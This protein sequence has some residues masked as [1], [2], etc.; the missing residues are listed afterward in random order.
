MGSWPD[1]SRP[2]CLPA[3]QAL[4]IHLQ[5]FVIIARLDVAYPGAITACMSAFSSLTWAG[6][7]LG[8]SPAC[9]ARDLDSGS[10]AAAQLL[11]GLLMPCVVVL[12]SLA[13]WALRWAGQ[14]DERFA[15]RVGWGGLCCAVR[16]LTTLQIQ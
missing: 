11:G 15:V 1:D 12:L 6:D 9:L 5:Y 3:P 14:A 10:Q 7:L 16:G 4:I 8:F 2:V 13:L